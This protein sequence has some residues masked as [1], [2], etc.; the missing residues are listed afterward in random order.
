MT[1]EGWLNILLIYINHYYLSLSSTMSD[2]LSNI[3]LVLILLSIVFFAWYWTIDQTTYWT[4][5]VQLEY[6][7]RMCDI[8]EWDPFVERVADVNKYS[9]EWGTVCVIVRNGIHSV[10]SWGLGGMLY[11]VPGSPSN[12]WGQIVR[13]VPF[14]SETHFQRNDE[15]G[16][17]RLWYIEYQRSNWVNPKSIVVQSQGTFSSWFKKSE[18][19]K[20][21]KD[22]LKKNITTTWW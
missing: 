6:K 16:F 5:C 10:E 2:K 3:L 15:N 11:P 4:G 21:I 20:G 13:R 8:F 18:T 17:N 9:C 14:Y 22:M 19:N 1:C 12:V 7:D